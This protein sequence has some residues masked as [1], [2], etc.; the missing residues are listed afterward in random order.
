MKFLS[1]HSKYKFTDEIIELLREC[2]SFTFSVSFI[3]KAGLVLLEK[4][5]ESALK[6]GAAGRILTS[7]YQNFTDIES[8][9][10]FLN[11]SSIYSNFK[12]HLD[13]KSLNDVGFHTKGYI[14][15]INSKYKVI[16]GST[17]ITRFALEKNFEWNTLNDL[18][19]LEINDIIEQFENLWSTTFVLNDEIINN[20]SKLLEYGVFRWD[21]D[22]GKLISVKAHPANYM[23]LKALN[24]LKRLRSIGVNKALI[25]AATG[26]GK[27]YLAAL[28]SFNFQ[29][30]KLLFIVHRDTI[31]DNAMKT[32]SSLFQETKKF[33][34]LNMSKKDFDADFIFSS[35]T[36]MSKNLDRFD[37]YHFDYIIID[38]VHHATAGT[39]QKIVEHFK[40]KFLLG[41]TA[42]PERMDQKSVFEI[43]DYNVPY[44]LRMREA[45]LNDLIV[46]FKY[47]GIKNENLDFDPTRSDLDLIKQ[48][49]KEDNIDF[50]I[51]N[52][53]KYKPNSKLKALAF[54]RTVQHA[55]Q[56]SE[57]FNN[58]G[59]NTVYLTGVDDTSTRIQNFELLQN[60][61]SKLEIIFCV[62]ILNEGVDIP[63]VNMVLFLR[64]TES[65]TVFIQQLG[66]GLRKFN[67]KNHL[68]VVDFIGNSYRRS[69]QIA[70]ALGT[71]SDSPYNDKKM[72]ANLVQN[73]FKELNIS[74]LEVHIDEFS[75][76]EILNSILSTNFN[77]TDYLKKD[78]LN[79][80]NYIG[81]KTFLNHMDFLNNDLSFDIL[82]II[83]IFGSLYNFQLKIKEDI[84]E[85]NDVQSS[86]L[87]YLSEYLPM[88]EQYSFRIIQNL[89]TGPK[90]KKELEFELSKEIEDFNLEKFNYYY[91]YVQDKYYSD[92]EL[93]RRKVFVKEIDNLLLLSIDLDNQNFKELIVD[94]IEYGVSRYLID[95]HDHKD[96]FK[97]HSVYS[98]KQF[99]TM[100]R[101]D[102]LSFREGIKY[103]K[104]ELYLFIDIKKDS[105]K[106]DHLKYEDEI[107]DKF[108]L[109]WES[110]TETT[111]NNTKGQKLIKSKIAHIFVRKTK[112]ED[113]VTLPY[114]YLGIG[115]LYNPRKSN[116]LKESLLF[117][118]KLYN[119]TPDFL[120]TELGLQA[121]E[122][123]S[124]P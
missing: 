123:K 1:N 6:R 59:F 23:Q 63:G 101:E 48:Y 72:L 12:C 86:F 22:S 76:E 83:K 118:V 31:L 16:I 14:F 64:P 58:R 25:V 97:L 4:E 20:Y 112:K 24:E 17:N 94:L 50:I 13:H 42:T 8:L 3:K 109:I 80:K 95:F 113:G 18:D 88:V 40:P 87:E 117:D 124:L 68:I 57:I 27:T 15:K 41:L 92:K 114:V 5:I 100:L 89:I 35:N 21:M 108:N 9:K 19:N 38:E 45:M 96:V 53:N 70:L 28:D 75:K 47:Y 55:K 110:S 11:W 26:S 119:Q 111:L 79:Y 120:L 29:P 61:Q 37:P 74:G 52:I 49:A 91:N 62:D 44:E 43:F 104:G 33:G 54:C 93:L 81:S 30:N 99:M 71:L 69:M 65:S 121:F 39:Y 67:N 82:R 10:T 85:L 51:E 32:F 105:K 60:D 116:N 7:T 122:P 34:L 2:D 78:Y 106:A 56:M 36:S 107:L 77:S 115:D 103:N 102:Y 66:R 73:D 90:S 46:P 98:R 84:T